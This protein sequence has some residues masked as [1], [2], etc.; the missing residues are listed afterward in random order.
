MS[1]CQALH[2]D[3][4]DQSDDDDDFVAADDD[5]DDH[6]G[7]G[8]DA[9]EEVGDNG[10]ADLRRRQVEE[11]MF[12]DAEE[13]DQSQVDDPNNIDNPDNPN[14]RVPVILRST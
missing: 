4:A 8:G 7:E 6:V 13:D 12:E 1:Q 11:G 3:P 10:D 9:E 2:P 5:E 14:K